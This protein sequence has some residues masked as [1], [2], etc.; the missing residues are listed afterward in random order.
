[1]AEA[2]SK[3]TAVTPDA[4]G[5]DCTFRRALDVANQTRGAEI[6]FDHKVFRSSQ[7]GSSFTPTQIVVDPATGS[8][9]DSGHFRI[10]AN[11]IVVDA[12][13]D[14]DRDG[15]IAPCMPAS[16]DNSDP[17]V[18]R[19]RV[20]I[21]LPTISPDPLNDGCRSVVGSECRLG[22]N[23]VLQVGAAAAPVEGTEVLGLLISGARTL[24]GAIEVNGRGNRIEHNVLADTFT[25][26]FVG[27]PGGTAA[28][29][30]VDNYIGPLA[31]LGLGGTT[32]GISVV[33]AGNVVGAPGHGNRIREARTYGINLSIAK[34]TVP[35]GAF[36][37]SLRSNVV[38]GNEILG[39]GGTG[40]FEV[41]R[42]NSIGG[43]G[44]GEGNLI[45]GYE[46]SGMEVGG[47]ATSIQGNRIEANRGDGILLN[48]VAPA[49]QA[50][51]G[52]R[53][54]AVNRVI[55]N[56][57]WGV[58]TTEGSRN[59][60][61][62]NVLDANGAGPISGAD[63]TASDLLASPS[64]VTGRAGPGTSVEVFTGDGLV[65]SDMA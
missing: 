62:G 59:T 47:F 54:A 61:V 13:P 9:E 48:G 5:G 17:E 37:P 40:I 64:T 21:R 12:E 16:V 56:G 23:G 35:N 36:R 4:G 49:R 41:G 44:P 31:A 28:N 10:T 26:V 20:W 1:M 25:G 51:V 22:R 30:V 57:G 24:L 58:V 38:M 33:G 34:G 39:P 27:D 65:P 14:C 8:S 50:L 60:I 43:S 15:L 19:P 11:Q 53:G 7:D 6:K 3:C 29:V 18:L 52:G 63:A 2:Q 55:G 46:F 42:G 32:I 45:S